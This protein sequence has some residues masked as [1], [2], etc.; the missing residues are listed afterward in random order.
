ME[1]T[2]T[3]IITLVLGSSVITAIV[4]SIGTYFATSR[5]NKKERNFLFNKE[6]FMKL[7]SEASFVLGYIYDNKR[8]LQTIRNQIVNH[9]IDLKR[10]E[11]NRSEDELHKI[12]QDLFKVMNIYFDSLMCVHDEYVE[13]M[14]SIMNIYFDVAKSNNLTEDQIDELASMFEEFA[15]KENE[16]QMEINAYLKR[17]KEALLDT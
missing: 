12:K 7:Q 6:T 1:F 16:F 9:L 11:L 15:K 14:K 8:I 10:L 13:P 2:V 3:E 17:E 5:L 4:T